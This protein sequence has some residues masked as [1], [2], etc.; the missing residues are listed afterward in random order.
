MEDYIKITNI[1]LAKSLNNKD[2]QNFNRILHLKNGIIKF[3]ISDKI[4]RVEFNSYLIELNE[5]KKALSNAGYMIK[6]TKKAGRLQKFIQNL[7]K[8][9]QESFGTGKLECCKLNE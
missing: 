4:F 9:N 3:S 2:Y 7:A 1:E 5:I 6:E 8:T